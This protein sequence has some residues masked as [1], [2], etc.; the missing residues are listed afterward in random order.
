ML[1]APRVPVVTNDFPR[2]AVRHKLPRMI[3]ILNSYNEI[4]LIAACMVSVLVIVVVVPKPL[5]NLVT[6]AIAIAWLVSLFARL[7]ETLQEAS[8]NKNRRKN[9]KRQSTM[10][11]AIVSSDVR[12]SD[13]Y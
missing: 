11:C 13:R 4:L 6:L 8:E 1:L 9:R 2:I 5:S 3:V 7:V 10:R 12:F